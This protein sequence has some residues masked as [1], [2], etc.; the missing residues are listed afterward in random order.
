MIKSGTDREVDYGGYHAKSQPCKDKAGVHLHAVNWSFVTPHQDT[1]STDELKKALLEHGPLSVCV[2]AT[3]L[4]IAYK[5]GV[6]NEHDNGDINHAVLLTGWDDSRGAWRI[7]NSWTSR[8]GESGFMWIEYGSNKV[9]TL[10]AWVNAR[11]VYY[12]MPAR[13]YQLVKPTRPH[14]DPRRFQPPW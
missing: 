1:P 10:A 13:Y 2:N 3:S 9:G 8:W 5:H 11:S 4:F 6:F 7:K 12:N 14:L